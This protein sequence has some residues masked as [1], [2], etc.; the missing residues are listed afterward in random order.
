MEEEG[1]V[2]RDLEFRVDR[3]GY[4]ELIATLERRWLDLLAYWLGTL[5]ADDL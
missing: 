1:D 3:R 4:H 5:T 2:G